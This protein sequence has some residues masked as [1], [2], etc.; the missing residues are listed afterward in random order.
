VRVFSYERANAR[1]PSGDFLGSLETSMQKR[2]AGQFHALTNMDAAATYTNQQRFYP[3]RGK[4]KPLWEFKEHDH[5][6]YCF[7]GIYNGTLNVVLLSGWIKDKAG[8]TDREVREVAK[9][10]ELFSKFLA[11]YPKGE[12]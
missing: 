1:C 11:E 10:I 8:K 3:L 12:V 9:A 4:G 2:F 6:L 7:R 5:R